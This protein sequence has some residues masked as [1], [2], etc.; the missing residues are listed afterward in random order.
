MTYAVSLTDVFLI[1]YCHGLFASCLF[2]F[3]FFFTIRIY[4]FN[5]TPATV[6]VYVFFTPWK[7]LFWKALATLKHDLPGT[8]TCS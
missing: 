6:V 1:V 4:D 5:M 8:R 3:L 2:L 7:R